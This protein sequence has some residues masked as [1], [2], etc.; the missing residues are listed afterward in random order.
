MAS[1]PDAM[2][3]IHVVDDDTIVGHQGVPDDAIEGFFQRQGMAD[4]RMVDEVAQSESCAADSTMQLA[5]HG[6]PSEP[7]RGPEDKAGSLR[8]CSMKRIGGLLL[9]G[10]KSNGSGGVRVDVHKMTR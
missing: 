10:R 2:K 9:R 5:Q 3:H 6:C 8:Q 7:T 1:R 4:A